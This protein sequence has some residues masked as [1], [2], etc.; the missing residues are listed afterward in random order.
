M[1]RLCYVFAAPLLRFCCA[2]GASLA[3]F[4]LR[5]V[6]SLR[7][8]GYAFNST[9]TVSVLRFCGAFEAPLRRFCCA[10]DGALATPLRRLCSVF[11]TLLRRI[12]CAFGAFWRAQLTTT[13]PFG[14]REALAARLLGMHSCFIVLTTGV[15]PLQQAPSSSFRF[16]G[17]TCMHGIVCI[18]LYNV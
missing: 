16:R 5:L 14:K 15:R 17:S 11:A 8:L 18:D 2:F 9:V 7:R 13:L 6:A 1:R 12:C 3:A 10:V 4:L